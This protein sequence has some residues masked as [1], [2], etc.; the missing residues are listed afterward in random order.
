MT[1]KKIAILG[2]GMAGL[3]AAYELTRTQD[4]R[5]L[6]E[7]TVYQMGWRLGGKAASGRD[8]RDRNLEHGLHVW[9]GCYHNMFRLTQEVY[10][11]WN[12]PAGCP[13]QTWRDVARPQDYTPLGVRYGGRWTYFPLTWPTNGAV[14]GQ[15]G[16]NMSAQ[17]AFTALLNLVAEAVK[18]VIG[19]WTGLWGKSGAPA[20]VPAAVR[21][22]VLPDTFSDATQESPALDGGERLRAQKL[23][24]ESRMSVLTLSR[25]LDAAVLWSKALE[26]HPAAR[27]RA[28]ADALLDFFDDIEATYDAIFQGAKSAAAPPSGAKWMIIRQ[29]LHL[30]GAVQ[31]G[32]VHDLFLPDQPFEA[33]DDLDFRDWLVRHGARRDV[34]DE[35]SIVHALYDTMFQYV[36][37]DVGRPSYA[38]GS[39]LGVLVRLIGTFKGSVMWNIQ[40][41][42]GEAVVAPLYEVLRDRGVQFRF[43]RKVK[44]LDVAA[45]AIASIQLEVQA[46]AKNGDYAPT[47]LHPL[48][49]RCWPAQPDWDQL[50]DGDQLRAAGVNFESHWSA[51]PNPGAETLQ[52]GR[53]FDAVVLAIAMGAYKPLN[54][55]PTMCSDL[56][57]ANPRFASFVQRMELV[58]S[59]SVQLWTD[60]TR[61]ALGWTTGQAALVSGP[62]Y[63]N[64][65]ADMSQVLRYEQGPGQPR[66]LYYL[67]G[68]LNTQLHK[69]PS[70]ATGT[71]AQALAGLRDST[72]AW[73][74]ESSY[75]MWPR[76]GE[77]GS[78][79]YELLSDPDNRT[80]VQRLDAQYLR[81]NID[82]TECCVASVAG[83]TRY[84]LLANESGF[85]NL[86]LA[87]E[88]TRHGFNTTTIE[89]AVMSGMA[90]A[91]AICGQPVTIVGHDFLRVR[92][93][94]T[95]Q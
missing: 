65:W 17:Q 12:K 40:A 68:T 94:E 45:D 20:P 95:P 86:V 11:A 74:Q 54:E 89:G 5:E 6:H 85:A 92:P 82:P 19:D 24:A 9:F 52:A 62:Q 2:G 13:L 7:V 66:A 87:G 77:G 10:D 59:Q 57:A 55:E 61:E 73:L 63:L 72:I 41:G 58:P 26:S 39:A 25:K 23:C 64:I 15:G 88:A 76:A 46:E 93:S 71:P 84:R 44:K 78:F 49:L 32:F 60:W 75:V 3:S 81:A 31:R 8:H 14:P 51:V 69:A 67:T 28:Q 53:D 18:G 47:Y 43:F 29:L 34:V 90:A 50:V 16:L 21:P 4:L 56:I 27:D 1:K 91:R 22:F 35:S 33:L 42:M 36:D 79:R 37:G 80:G 83:T 38:A 30:F 48:N 70:T